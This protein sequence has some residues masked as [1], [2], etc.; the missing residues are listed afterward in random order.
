[1]L[2]RLKAKGSKAK[3]AVNNGSTPAVVETESTIDILGMLKE[4]NSDTGD[5]PNKFDS[6]NGH[7]KITSEAKL[8]RKG[9]SSD[10][11]NVSV[12]KRRRSSSAKSQKRSTFLSSGFKSGAAFN[13]NKVEDEKAPVHKKDSSDTDDLDLEVLFAL[14]HGHVIFIFIS[15][16]LFLE[17]HFCFN[18]I[19]SQK[20]SWRLIIIKSRR[21]SR[22]GKEDALQD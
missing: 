21:Q 7:G 5:V 9:M 10:L 14:K 6:S 1:M 16:R 20:S 8:K 2:K 22:S 17:N 3:K 4:I 12:P 19:Q 18:L 15:R 11:T 13:I